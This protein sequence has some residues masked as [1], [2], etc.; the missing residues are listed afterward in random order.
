MPGKPPNRA[1]E[2]EMTETY[3]EQ[4]YYTMVLSA[5]EGK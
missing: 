3:D 1:G 4:N 2:C 5:L